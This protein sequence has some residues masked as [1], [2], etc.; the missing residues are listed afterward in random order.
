MKKKTNQ[1]QKWNKLHSI[2]DLQQI[3]AYEAVNK[4]I[5]E[6]IKP[7]MD[8]QQKANEI[9]AHHRK[10]M[11]IAQQIMGT[12]Q[13]EI[14]LANKIGQIY[15]NTSFKYYMEQMEQIQKLAEAG[16]KRF[17]E[18]FTNG[19]QNFDSPENYDPKKFKV[20]PWLKD[21]L[22]IEV[23]ELLKDFSN[24]PFSCYKERYEK[25]YNQFAKGEYTLPI[26]TFFSI[27]DGLMTVLCKLNK[28]LKPNRG[29]NYSYGKKFTE[30]MSKYGI[31]AHMIENKVF[32]KNL[33]SFYAHRHEIMHGGI[34]AHFDK[35]I[36]MIALIF[37]VYTNLIVK[38]E[39]VKKSP[40]VKK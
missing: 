15:D 10:Q 24:G 33:Q 38:D 9:L 2:V 18:A 14:E 8:A 29:D 11:E 40:K 22:E 25:A 30:L 21:Q 3:K 28:N 1:M 5:S 17:N 6:Q 19:I 39:I 23:E 26:F 35:N 31:T 27:Q 12:R 32:G 13:R 37:L 36:A 4:V 34:N 7:L 20:D 16:R